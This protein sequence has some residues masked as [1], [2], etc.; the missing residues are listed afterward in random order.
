MVLRSARPGDPHASPDGSQ[1]CVIYGVPPDLNSPDAFF[2]TPWEAYTYDANDLAPLSEGRGADDNPIPLTNR[3]PASHHFTPSNIE[4]DALGR[5]IRN[6]QRNGAAPADEITTLS[7]YDIRGNVL[8]VVDALGRTAFRYIYDLANRPMRVHTIDAGIK[9]TVLDAFGNAI[10]QRDSKGA[11]VLS[12]F[13]ALNRPTDIWARDDAARRVTLREHLVYGDNA[14]QIG[15][16]QANARQRN[17]LGELV[18]HYDEAGRVLAREY[19]FKGNLLEKTRQVVS[20]QEILSAFEGAAA[21]NWQVS[22]YQIDWQSEGFSIEIRA[23]AILDPAE[24]TTTTRYDGLSRVREVE[25]PRDVENERKV[26]RPRYNRAGA[27]ENVTFDGDIYV[28]RITYD[29]KGQRMLIAY[30]NGVMTRFAYD[31]RTFRLTRL[32]SERYSQPSNSSY[33]PTGMPLQDFGYEYDLA[34][35]IAS[36]RDR[37]PES[38]IPNTLQGTDALDRQFTYD[39]IYRLLS[40]TGRECDIRPPIPPWLDEPRCSDVTRTRAYTE[41]YQY[42]PLGNMLVL[43]HQNSNGGFTRAFA[44]AATSN[45]LD[46]LTSG[47]TDFAYTYDASGNMTAET[48][49]RHFEWDHGNR[50]KVFRTQTQGAEPSVYAHYLYDASGIRL[51]RLVRRQG[52][53][54]EVTAYLD[55]VFEH[56]RRVAFGNI[57]EN[58][59]LHIVDDWQKVGL[60]RIGESFADDSSPAVRF[61]IGDHLGSCNVITGDTGDLFNREEFTPYGETS[62]GSYSRKR[63][64]FTGKM[65][66]DESGL[67][68]HEVRYYVPWLARWSTADPTGPVDGTNLYN[69][70]RSNP[71]TWRDLGG[72]FSSPVADDGAP[73]VTGGAPST[74]DT[75]AANKLPEDKEL[76][77]LFIQLSNQNLFEFWDILGKKL[78]AAGFDK[79]TAIGT[80]KPPKTWLREIEMADLLV[81][82]GHH[83]VEAASPEDPTRLG[84]PGQFRT[85]EFRQVNLTDLARLKK[86]PLSERTQLIIVTGCNTLRP[87][88][89][90]FLR[91]EFPNATIIGWANPSQET[92][93]WR[94]WEE[95]ARKL[96]LEPNAIGHSAAVA[97]IRTIEDAK[98]KL[99]KG[100]ITSSHSKTLSLLHSSPAVYL[101]FSPVRVRGVAQNGILYKGSL[102]RKAKRLELKTEGKFKVPP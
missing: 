9:R 57:T 27:L 91:K 22:A 48:T 96:D 95:F 31:P 35:N 40:A 23:A 13:D 26:L 43:Q 30:G 64:R 19:D 100:E 49:S 24:Y 54:F 62:F 71:L 85:A 60:V 88:A 53:Q 45:R 68:Y 50:M 81:I 33:Q 101:P 1:Q 28:Q 36:I 89:L 73:S 98:V 12:A 37:T 102:L 38:G 80:S 93:Q 56:D 51:K 39:A 7:S 4:I 61:Q 83:Y 92:G 5:M 46:T 69:Y 70:A 84:D 75:Q 20:D 15:I 99:E 18:A 78:E 58:N 63:F 97:W 29:A 86:G 2:P 34:G 65:R 87:R 59:T 94:L 25:Y 16:D 21:S 8:T 17:A 14:M 77:A 6:T 74:V 66:D 76:H 67:C 79:P 10:E 11:L 72:R 44:I 32:R 3:A 52:G 41:R 42:G 82:T 55:D 47:Q 90:K